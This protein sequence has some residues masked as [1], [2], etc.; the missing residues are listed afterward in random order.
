MD[1][2]SQEI[3]DL[4]K[5]LFEYVPNINHAHTTEKYVG[6]DELILLWAFYEAENKFR[7]LVVVDSFVVPLIT[8]PFKYRSAAREHL[9]SFI[10]TLNKKIT[11]S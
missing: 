1:T 6:N 5:A 4:E 9:I 7:L 8:S 11:S 3:K 10:D 2:V